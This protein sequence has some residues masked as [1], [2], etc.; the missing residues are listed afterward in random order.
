MGVIYMY[1]TT[2]WNSEQIVFNLWESVITSIGSVQGYDHPRLY[3]LQKR[4]RFHAE[5][6]V[7][8]LKFGAI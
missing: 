3:L 5:T 4:H 6:G 7:R 8:L 2:P 1:L